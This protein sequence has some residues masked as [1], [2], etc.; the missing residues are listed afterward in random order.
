MSE[1]IS[2]KPEKDLEFHGFSSKIN[3][4][5]ILRRPNEPKCEENEGFC[6]AEE[7]AEQL[8]ESRSIRLRAEPNED[9]TELSIKGDVQPAELLESL[10][11]QKNDEPLFEDSEIS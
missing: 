2:E 4:G 3:I 10:G 11:L 9:V 1:P 8:A 5:L 6:D 7:I